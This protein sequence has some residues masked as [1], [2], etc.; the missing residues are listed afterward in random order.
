MNLAFFENIFF[1][2][3]KNPLLTAFIVA[4]LICILLWFIGGSTARSIALV[5]IVLGLCISSFNWGLSL[6]KPDQWNVLISVATLLA[7]LTALFADVIQKLV[8]RERITV[9][10][11][12]VFIDLNGVRWVRCRITNSGDRAVQ[13]C[14]VKLLRIEQQPT[15]VENGFLQWQ[16][17]IREPLTISSREHLI[18]DIATRPAAHGMPLTL[19]A[20]IGPNQLAQDLAPG[21]TYSVMMSIYGDNVRT[22]TKTVAITLGA[23]AHQIEVS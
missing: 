8:Y 17:G 1:T 12:P 7:V 22:R 9:D 23:A 2:I 16:G 6:G 5:L 15:A 14:R 21:H 3:A 4:L 19:L 10:V 11:E 20:Y 18:F 13:R